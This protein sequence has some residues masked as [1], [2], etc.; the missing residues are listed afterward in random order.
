[1]NT[2]K[3]E[4]R[5]GLHTRQASK[6]IPVNNTD[7]SAMSAVLNQ[8]ARRFGTSAEVAAVIADLARLGP[9]EARR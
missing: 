7:Y 1:M 6:T 2:E 4:A 8:I 5:T 3:S 9:K